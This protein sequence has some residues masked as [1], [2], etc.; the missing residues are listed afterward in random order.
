MNEPATLL[1]IF[2][3]EGQRDGHQPLYAAIVEELRSD[4]FQGVTVLKGIDGFGINRHLH[5]A[6]VVDVTM[7]LPII[8]EIIERRDKI[9]AIIPRLTE[10]IPEGLLTLENLQVI[11]IRRSEP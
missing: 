3:L 5:S 10:M 6:R 9:D 4:G 8:I 11:T 2:L 1:R 7:N